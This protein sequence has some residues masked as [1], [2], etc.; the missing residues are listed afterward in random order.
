MSFAVNDFSPE[1]DPWHSKRVV[2]AHGCFDLLHLGHIRHLQEAK[3][4][5]D[6]LIVSVTDDPHV[7][8]GVG[9]PVF[10]VEQRA[11]ALRALECVDGVIVNYRADAVDV[12]KAVGPAVYVKGADYLDRN[13]EALEREIA[14]ITE[15]G[16]QFYITRTDS[17]SSS[18][19]INGERLSE[20]CV[21]YLDSARPRGFLDR[22]RAAFDRA[23]QMAI[24]FIGETIVDEY[25]YVTPLGRPVKEFCLATVKARESEAFLGGVV[26]ASKH[27]EWA[28]LNVLTNS[29]VTITK[30]RY[31]DSAFNRKLFEVY[32]DRELELIPTQ[33]AKFQMELAEAVKSSDVVIVLD[34]GHGLLGAP[35]REMVAAS[36]FLA[37]N[38]QTNTGNFG[39]NPVTKYMRAD[40]VCVDEPE[41]RLATGMQIEPIRDVASKLAETMHAQN[42]IMTNGRSGC[43]SCF[44]HGYPIHTPA[45]ASNG[46]DTMGAGDAFLAVTAP[47][48]AAGLD[49]E[50][51]ALVGN[52]AGALKVSIIGHRRHVGRD[53]LLQ[54]VEALLK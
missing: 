26:A 12:I 54:S 20:E 25:R 15:L 11:E 18:R 35:E 3:A 14:A 29:N 41:A 32:S 46:I 53:E 10:T 49:L 23:D 37:I 17:W 50:A 52:V 30:T 39:F 27:A 2:L 21:A 36:R 13:D 8:K 45:F 16:G 33:R 48:I 19:I 5:G 47:L 38:A 34:F 24:T 51:A 31:V 42:T 9:R 1:A 4:Q 40:Y 44:R 7:R 28:K 22:I 43:L 6:H